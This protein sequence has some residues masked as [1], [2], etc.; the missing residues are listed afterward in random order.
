MLAAPMRAHRFFDHTGDIGADLE[1]DEEAALF[2]ASI[3]AL[4]AVLVEDPSAVEEREV[5]ALEVAG[6]DPEAQLVALG[7]EVLYAFE[8][9]WLARRVEVDALREDGLAATAIGEPFDPA[10]HAIARPIKAVTHHGAR[11]EETAPGRWVGRVV[12]DL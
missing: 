8:M 3:D 7:N 9:G 5:R 11:V 2:E 4:V 10:R 12:F 1:A 6:D